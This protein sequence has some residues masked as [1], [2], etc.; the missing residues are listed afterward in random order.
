MTDI[1]GKKIETVFEGT[2]P[3]GESKYFIDAANYI[4]GTY[5]VSLKTDYSTQVQKLIVK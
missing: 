4:S 3:S 1:L 5:F 2:I